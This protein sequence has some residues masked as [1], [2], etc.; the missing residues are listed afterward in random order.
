MNLHPDL[1]D[2]LQRVRLGLQPLPL[3]ALDVHLEVGDGTLQ[4][5][6]LR[7]DVPQCGQLPSA[8]GGPRA[9]AQSYRMKH[10]SVGV[11]RRLPQTR[12]ERVHLTAK[13]SDDVDLET[14]LVIA[15][16]R[17]D[18]AGRPRSQWS[19]QTDE[20]VAV[21]DGLVAAYDPV[22]FTSEHGETATPALRQLDVGEE[23]GG[24][25]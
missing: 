23:L 14:P 3:A 15:A 17:V 11:A 6:Q 1:K 7:A 19:V 12:V 24:E 2:V 4:V 13:L 21:D 5:P 18:E 8:G 16:E 22:R 9:A 10:R 25:L 20:L